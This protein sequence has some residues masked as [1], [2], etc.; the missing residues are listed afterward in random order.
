MLLF[1]LLFFIPLLSTV[2]TYP[3]GL[4]INDR[5]SQ[6]ISSSLISI[7]AIVSWLCLYNYVNDDLNPFV[8]DIFSWILISGSYLDWSIA[9]NPLTLLMLTLV[10][11]VSALVHIY[12][13]EYMSHDKSKNRFMVYL[14]LF[15]FCM[16]SLVVSDNI[17]QLFFGWEGVGLASYLLIGFWHHK[18]T[19]NNAAI[20]AFLVNRIA[21][22]GFLIGIAL[23]YIYSDSLSITDIIASKD[24]LKSIPINFISIETD[25][26]TISCFFLFIGAM[27]KSAQFGFHTWLPDAMEGPT[28]VS[29]LIHAATMVTAGVFLTVRF[30]ELIVMSDFILNFILVVGLITAFFA[31]SVAL[32]QKDI[33]KVIAYS[34]CS[35]LG[36]MFVACGLGAF[37]VAIFHLITHGYFKALLFLSSGS[38]IHGVHDEQDMDKMGNLFSKMKITT[39]VMWI[40]TL[41]IIGFPYMSGYYSK[42]LILNA[43]FNLNEW[44]SLVYILL[45]IISAMTAFYSF[46]LIFKVFHGKYNGNYD[47]EKIHESNFIMLIPLF[48]LSFGSIFAGY[49]FNEILSGHSPSDFWG[50]VI[51]LSNETHP[52]SSIYAIFSKSMIT[53]A[54]L[55]CIYMYA[56][57]LEKIA[58]LKKQFSKFYNFLLNKWF[59]D[60]FYNKYIVSPFYN[61]GL[62]LWKKIDQNIIDRLLPNGSALVISKI[63]IFC[64]KIQTGFIFDYTFVIIAGFT[65]FISIIFYFAI[66]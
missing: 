6:I 49:F 30:S 50:G 56:L 5:A 37:N 25:V 35:Q 26:L 33:K 16:V 15:T 4:L 20:K 19:A 34:T 44:G 24:Y 23:L 12:S 61:S 14:S 60:E 63:S 43:S 48:I 21:D 36:F 32:F 65:F 31:A 55:L 1:K 45:A 29:A 3:A 42:D 39:I 54:I 59:F 28:P 17:V 2:I 10:L 8:I 51:F 27:G 9:V 41:A 58:N 11:T 52:H 66:L 64:K 62:I 40:G 47:Y 13:I 7:S 18:K 38:V 57:N 46:R 53:F 22:F